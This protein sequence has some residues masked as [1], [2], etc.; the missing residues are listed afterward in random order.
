M[1]RGLIAPFAPGRQYHGC[2]LTFK[3]ASAYF[4]SYSPAADKMPQ[5]LSSFSFIAQSLPSC[6]LPTVHGGSHTPSPAERLP[7]HCQAIQMR[8]ALPTT[9]A[10]IL[11]QRSSDANALKNG[12]DLTTSKERARE[13]RKDDV[14]SPDSSTSSPISAAWRNDQHFRPAQRQTFVACT[15]RSGGTTGL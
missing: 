1:A 2:R 4:T 10:L 14:S 7:V 6:T 13:E 5:A 8:P 9:A 3:V 11:Y 15:W 12:I